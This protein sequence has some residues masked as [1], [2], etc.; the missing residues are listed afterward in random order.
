MFEY[1]AKT[2]QITYWIDKTQIKE[3]QNHTLKV[4]V[5]DNCGN[6]SEFSKQIY[7]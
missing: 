4:V 6:V 3:F 2:Q 7:W 1:D 5:K